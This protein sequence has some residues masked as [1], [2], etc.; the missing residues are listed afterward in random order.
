MDSHR[1]KEPIEQT[2]DLKLTFN[3]LNVAEGRHAR[4]ALGVPA[5]RA[6]ERVDGR[7]AEAL[8]DLGDFAPFPPFLDL[9]T[10]A[11]L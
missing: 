8:L 4:P 6:A 1:A 2:P 5:A 10:I 9:V 3:A 11:N 7:V